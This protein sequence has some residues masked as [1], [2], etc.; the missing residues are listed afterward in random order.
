MSALPRS[1]R[2]PEGGGACTRGG[3]AGAGD[4]PRS[5]PR[6]D[7]RRIGGDGARGVGV[8]ELARTCKL[9]ATGEKTIPQSRTR[10]ARPRGANALPARAFVPLCDPS[11]MSAMAVTYAGPSS[12]LIQGGGDEGGFD[13]G[14]DEGS[15]EAM[16]ATV[17][18]LPIPAWVLLLRAADSSYSAVALAALKTSIVTSRRTTSAERAM[19]MTIRRAAMARA[20]L[21][22]APP[23][24]VVGFFSDLLRDSSV[25]P[26]ELAGR[27]VRIR[28]PRW[29]LKSKY[30]SVALSASAMTHASPS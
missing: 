18:L 14:G 6:S 27:R 29:L 17:T 10:G 23:M 22:G 1:G 8:A 11:A 26:C 21:G 5:G 20:S 3:G 4:G 19:T 9:E 13:D 30:E 2:S 25:P 24:P 28:I 12:S 15:D 16:A 7:G